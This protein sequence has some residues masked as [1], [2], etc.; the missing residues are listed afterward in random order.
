MPINQHM[1][2][3]QIFSIVKFS[4]KFA[5][6]KPMKWHLRK[7]NTQPLIEECSSMLIIKLVSKYLSTIKENLTYNK[8]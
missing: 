8:P 2:M 5:S 1:L 7:Q 6:W 3:L 4:C